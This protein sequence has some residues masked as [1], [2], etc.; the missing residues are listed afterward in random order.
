MSTR[1]VALVVTGSLSALLVTGCQSLKPSWI[2]RLPWKSENKVQESEFE[3]PTRMASLWSP[4]VLTQPGHPP[5]RGLGGRFFFYDLRG[6]TIPVEG[7]LVVYAY[8]DG[9]AGNSQTPTRKF[10]FT[11]EQL[12]QHVGSTELGV[13]YSVWLPWDRVGGDQTSLS[14]VPVFTATSGKIVMGKQALAV[15]PGRVKPSSP[16]ESAPEQVQP[17]VYDQTSPSQRPSIRERRPL[18]MRTTTFDL[19]PSLRHRI[20][21]AGDSRV[22]VTPRS[23]ADV[24]AAAAALASSPPT[25]TKAPATGWE[26]PTPAS[27][28]ERPRYPAPRAPKWRSRPSDAGW[29][30]PLPVPPSVPPASQPPQGPPYSHPGVGQVGP[31]NQY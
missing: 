19:T 27:H 31:G 26:R 7:Q 23:A 13:S 17:V 21:A 4:D 16:P 30:Q 1:C 29:I 25:A 9:E 28:F 14:L 20:Q 18:Q 11:P 10:V 3:E 24:A 2:D 5:V 8:D 12:T 15:L 22:L 6:D